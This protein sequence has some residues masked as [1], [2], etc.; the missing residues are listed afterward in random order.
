MRR[1]V[2]LEACRDVRVDVHAG[3][4]RRTCCCFPFTG[5]GASAVHGCV[6]ACAC[7]NHARRFE[8][9]LK[10]FSPHV[11]MVEVIYIDYKAV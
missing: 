7:S 9:E 4:R 3:V 2:L 6:C 5:E 10:S 1:V 8:M 11:L